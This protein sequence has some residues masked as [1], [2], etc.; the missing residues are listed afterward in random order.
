[1]NTVPFVPQ[2]NIA[3]LLLTVM[4]LSACDGGSSAGIA[5]EEKRVDGKALSSDDEAAAE[6]VRATLA[7]H[8]L[9]TPDGWTTQFQ[10]FNVLGELMPDLRPNTLYKQIRVLSFTIAPDTVTEAMK[11]NGTDH[12]VTANF[13]DSPVRFYRVEAD[14]EGP[15]GW[16]SWQDESMMFTRLAIER[17]NGKWI[18]SDS[19]L[20]EG[21]R[22]DA[23]EVPR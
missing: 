3:W 13:K 7:G 10:K 8:W 9:E 17:R 18:V 11:L 16:D 23:A 4:S 20:F 19:D 12:R 21:I 15:Q 14:F 22:P 5:V 6:F 1:M 2:I